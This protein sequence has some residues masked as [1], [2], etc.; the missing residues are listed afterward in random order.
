MTDKRVCANRADLDEI[1]ESILH[2][3]SLFDAIYLA[4]WDFPAGERGKE[5]GIA[6]SSAHIGAKIMK[7]L[8]DELSEMIDRGRRR[9]N[10]GD[11]R[12]FGCYGA[13]D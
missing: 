5:L 10:A 8:G 12:D 1:Y 9:K 4:I 13:S 11:Y 3:T 7:E 2:V 6:V